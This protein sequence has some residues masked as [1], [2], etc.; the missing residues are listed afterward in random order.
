LSRDR[1]ARPRSAAEVID[2]LTAIAG[3]EEDDR[4]A[5]SHAYLATPELAGR[6]AELARVRAQIAR[7]GAAPCAP[8]LFAGAPGTGRSRMLD[9]AVL[10]AKLAGIQVARA[11]AADAVGPY[12]TVVSLLRP[13]IDTLL[14]RELAL[15]GAGGA[16][17]LLER[18]AISAE[19]DKQRRSELQ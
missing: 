2:R 13:L 1:T 17:G 11:S 16:L 7:V 10:E 14:P 19:V 4:L 12:G 5:V 6:D 8:L 3:L 15:L 18:A 9:T